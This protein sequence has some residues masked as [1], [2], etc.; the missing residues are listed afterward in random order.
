MSDP[1]SKPSA[2]PNATISKDEYE[3]EL[4]A[5]DDA[6]E[7]ETWQQW[8]HELNQLTK[9]ELIQ[10]LSEARELEDQLWFELFFRNGKITAF[11]EK[12]KLI[13]SQRHERI[14]KIKLGRQAG[15]KAKVAAGNEAIALGVDDFYGLI[16]EAILRLK[17]YPSLE[18]NHPTITKAIRAII[19]DMLMDENLSCYSHDRRDWINIVAR[20][21]NSRHI[22]IAKSRLNRS[23]QPDSTK[24]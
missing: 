15:A 17:D 21:I 23:I 16:C 1:K 12:I 7:F 13:D 22:G 4:Y 6:P 2:K 14:E 18:E 8:L 10:L 9:K 3:Q 19:V 24:N 5:I 20:S 11:E